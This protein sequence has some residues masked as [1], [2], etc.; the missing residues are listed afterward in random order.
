M[1]DL[2]KPFRFSFLP[3]VTSKL[4][5]IAAIAVSQ[6]LVQELTADLKFI[7]ERLTTDPTDWGDPLFD[8]KSLGMTR[9]RGRSIFLYVYYSVRETEKMVFVQEIEW[10]PYGP[11]SRG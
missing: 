8:Y 1:D 11:L 9:Y 4:E 3:V 10:N 7:Q 5:S 2:S 6:K